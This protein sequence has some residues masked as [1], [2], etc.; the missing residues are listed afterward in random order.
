MLPFKAKV[1]IVGAGGTGI[2]AYRE[3]TK[4]TDEA[5]LIENGP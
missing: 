3:V 1:A 4:T 2:L 5:R